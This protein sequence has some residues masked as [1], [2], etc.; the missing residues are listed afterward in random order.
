MT[1][2]LQEPTEEKMLEAIAEYFATARRLFEGTYMFVPSGA[3][4]ITCP[5]CGSTSPGV[6]YH[7]GWRCLWQHCNFTFPEK[8]APPSPRELAELF[9][10]AKRLR[11]ITVWNELLSRHGISV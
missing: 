1:T 6:I 7:H 2:K 3:D 9:M 10:L 8:L 4:Q 5:K 11:T